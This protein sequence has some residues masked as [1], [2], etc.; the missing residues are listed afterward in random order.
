MRA[1]I[2]AASWPAR[3]RMGV[4]ALWAGLVLSRARA[5]GDA[6]ATPSTLA[7]T[8]LRALAY[9]V[10]LKER[11]GHSVVLAVVHRASSSPSRR[12]AQEMTKAFK[13]LE[14][15]TVQGLPFR[16][17]SLP[18]TD[19][20]TLEQGAHAAEVSI[21][22]VCAGLEDDLPAI[23]EVA[24]KLRIL[25]TAGKEALVQKGLSLAVDLEAKPSLVVNLK[26]SRDE[27]AAFSSAL[28]RLA[29]VIK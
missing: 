23:R 3:R 13:D 2:L 4:L 11:A 18:V 7:M 28:L 9:D 15:V 5:H 19:A 29:K 22:Y 27:G 6:L 10:N 1:R 17:V 21:F 25:T 16:V 24:L 14:A 26:Q 20:A 8:L 12:E